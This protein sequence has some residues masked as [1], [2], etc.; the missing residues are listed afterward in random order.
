MSRQ[1]AAT[2]RWLIET[3][4]FFAREQ[5]ALDL[6]AEP[7][8]AVAPRWFGPGGIAEDAFTQDWSKAADGG[9][10]WLNPQFRKTG[11]WITRLLDSGVRYVALTLANHDT[12]WWSAL[13]SGGSH[14][15]E[16]EGRIDFIPPPGV[17]YENTPNIRVA[18]WARD[19]ILPKRI[20]A[21]ALAFRY[22]DALMHLSEARGPGLS[23]ESVNAEALVESGLGSVFNRNSGQRIRISKE[24]M[25]IAKHLR[26]THG[27]NRA[28][29]QY[30]G[31]LF[32]PG[33]FEAVL[34]EEQKLERE[35][36]V[37]RAKVKAARQA[38]LIAYE[39]L[40]RF[41]IDRCG[42]GPLASC[43]HCKME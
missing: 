10:C 20:S 16:I 2:P 11:K 25:A 28:T 4:S 36:H 19:R 30:Q 23:V 31:L 33:G 29:T 5:F 21:R 39:A 24:G 3:I 17:T 13:K 1:N 9:L 18:L 8:T 15:T 27:S 22:W 26:R 43:K 6:A 38:Y 37:L 7:N 34:T 12:K 42:G 32:V 41:H 14:L 35:A 40:M